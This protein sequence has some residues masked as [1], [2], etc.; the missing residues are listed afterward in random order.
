MGRVLIK[1]GHTVAFAE[2]GEEFMKA[3]QSTGGDTKEA[4]GKASG[5]TAPSAP[6]FVQFDLVLIDRHM[7]KLDGPDATK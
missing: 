1:K 2:D 4:S 7:P 6:A 5:G 3:I